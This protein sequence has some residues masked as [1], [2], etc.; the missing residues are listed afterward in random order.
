MTIHRHP[1]KTSAATLLAD[2][3]IQ[4]IVPT[5]LRNFTTA[6]L[7]GTAFAAAL[8]TPPAQAADATWM[9]AGADDLWNTAGNWN[10]SVPGATTLPTTS[11]NIAT[12]NSNAAQLTVGIDAGRNIKSLSFDTGAGSFIIG[13]GGS[14]VGNAL[15]LTTGGAIRILSTITGTGLTETVNSP[16]LLQPTAAAGNVTYTMNSD[17]ANASNVLKIGGSVTVN[18]AGAGT[19]T[20]TGAN[21][22]DNTI[23]GD[24]SGATT[25]T[26]A[27]NKSGAGSW[28]L[29]GNVTTKGVG[30]PGG[31]AI[32]G[33]TI[34][35]TNS[36]TLTGKVTV[37]TTNVPGGT[38]VLNCSGNIALGTGAADY[39]TIGD[40][41]NGIM[42]VTAGTTTITPA[43]GKAFV[44]GTLDAG[45]TGT[46]IVNVS[47]GTVRLTNAAPIRFGAWEVTTAHSGA[48]FLNI[49]DSGLFDTGTTG[50]GIFLGIGSDASSGTIN[51]DGGTFQTMRN[52]T[53]G[54]G[55]ATFNFNGGTL[56]AMG[57]NATL[58][59]ANV[60]TNVKA[61]GAIIDTNSFNVSIVSPLQEDMISTGGG[62]TK[63]GNGTLTLNG[64]ATYTGNTNINAGTLALSVTGSLSGTP[65]INVASGATLNVAALAGNFFVGAPQT[66]VANGTVIGPVNV[67]GVLGGG[68]TINGAVNIDT[69]GKLGAGLG[70]AT[71]DVNGSLV[72]A[73]FSTLALQITGAIAGD[74][75]GFYSQVNMT[76]VIDS[77]SLLSGVQLSLSLSGFTPSVSDT[78]FIL[79]RADGLAFDTFFEGAEE[80]TTVDLGNGLS[81]K[82]TYLANWTGAEG[83]SSLTGGNDVAIYNVVPEPGTAAVLLTGLGALIALP[84][85][86]RRLSWQA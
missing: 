50:G 4:R 64:A 38:G 78:Y 69:D 61:S 71:L 18:T 82:I 31:M 44:I 43:I 36:V 67:D 72:F 7:L 30:V 79:T 77:V 65:Q 42:N 76:S 5:S 52:I 80:G 58:I 35:F 33:G 68:G 8:L 21:A 40:S 83:T 60:V 29:S 84:R 51:L 54:P 20:L 73:P 28:T 37:N 23:S 14:N 25:S 81:G 12:F 19:L 2:S 59:A 74:G 45:G 63:N 32:T 75:A 6:L 70:A 10:P 53:K 57:N 22:G 17:S 85:G 62:L 1:L 56:K 15:A 9:G 16:L 55:S 11:A 13:D 66:L 34:N 86:R 27:V 48:G 26:F 3:P 46:G 49:S 39:V 47:G 41:S 24:I